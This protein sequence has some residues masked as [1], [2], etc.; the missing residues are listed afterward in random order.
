M[1]KSALSFIAYHKWWTARHFCYFT[2]TDKISCRGW[3]SEDGEEARGAIICLCCSGVVYSSCSSW[4]TE[5]VLMWGI[6]WLRLSFCVR[7]KPWALHCEP[8]CLTGVAVC[9]IQHFYENSLED[10]TLFFVQHRITSEMNLQAASK[11][12]HLMLFKW[13]SNHLL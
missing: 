8:G 7:F 10:V 13:H 4:P 11:D 2:V 12:A 6:T 9:G 1:K 3:T 5:D